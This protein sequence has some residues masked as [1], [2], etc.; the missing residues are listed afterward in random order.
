[1][2]ARLLKLKF[3]WLPMGKLVLIPDMVVLILAA[4]VFGTVE[5]GTLRLDSALYLL[6]KVMDMVLYGLG[7][8]SSVAY[9]ITDRWEETVQAYCWIW[10]G[11]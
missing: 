7:Y 2:V 6:S 4:V 8:L 9:I 11:A 1:M 10:T 5:R 3:P